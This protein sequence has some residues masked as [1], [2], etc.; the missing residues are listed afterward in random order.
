MIRYLKQE[1]KGKTRAMYEANFPEDSQAFVDYYFSEKTKDNQILVM[2]ESGQLQV[3]IHLNPYVFSICGEP[4]DVNYVVAVATDEAVRKQGR[5]AQVM[6]RALQDMAEAHQPFTFLIPANPRVYVSSGF[7]FVPSEKYDAYKKQLAEE[8]GVKDT[9][10]QAAEIKHDVAGQNPAEA[11]RKPAVSQ[12]YDA[13]RMILQKAAVQDIPR[14]AA[15]SNELLAREYDI[16]PRRTEGYYQRM[17]AELVSQNG[18]LVLIEQKK[19]T[20][21]QNCK[22]VERKGRLAG[23]LSYSMEKAVPGQETEKR[24]DGI[25]CPTEEE[26]R[27]ELQEIL[28]MP[29]VRESFTDIIT[30]Y[31]GGCPA[32]ITDMNFMVR[33][34]DLRVLG[35]LLRSEEPF[36]IKVQVQDDIIAANCGCFEIK[37]DQTGSSITAISPEEAECS[38]DITELTKF[39]FNK[40]KLFIREWV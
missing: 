12:K 16:F 2:E 26:N 15:F 18:A 4:V 36:S 27:I 20:K 32:E 34:L 40:M 35:L 7:V 3:M 14:M 6:K 8:A 30:E 1:E 17:M 33:I 23:I 19:E 37:A 28:M 5:M 38:M 21:E 9:D 24:S 31:F 25:F 22:S 10:L 11:E 29:E 13:A 39:L